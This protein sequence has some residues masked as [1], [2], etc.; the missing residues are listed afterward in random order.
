METKSP[1]AND[2]HHEANRPRG[3]EA[4]RGNS[5][6]G[7]H[8]RFGDRRNS[9]PE[10][11]METKSPEANDVHHE[12]NRPRGDEAQ[13]GNSALGLHPRF[14]DRRNSATKYPQF[15]SRKPSNACGKAQE[16]IKLL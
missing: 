11:G 7:L 2:V 1:E 6:L 10:K 14:G 3:D 8:P 9:A 4:Q 5:A 15:L 13:R 12:A 16:R